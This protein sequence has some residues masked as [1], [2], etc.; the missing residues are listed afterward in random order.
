M[1]RATYEKIKRKMHDSKIFQY[2]IVD[3]MKGK[4][5]ASAFTLKAA[6]KRAAAEAKK[7]GHVHG[8]TRRIL[9][10]RKETMRKR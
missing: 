4:L 3:E 7:T 9:L 6:K 2:N 10:V 1:A 8:V 5:V